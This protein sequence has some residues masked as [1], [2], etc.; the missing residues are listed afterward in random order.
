MIYEDHCFECI[1]YLWEFVCE[2][3]EIL[4]SCAYVEILLVVCEMTDPLPGALSQCH[5]HH[6]IY[7]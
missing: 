6:H 1:Y 4:V 3:P 5:I 7:R 2:L